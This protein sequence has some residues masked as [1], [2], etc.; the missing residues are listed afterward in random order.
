MRRIV[1]KQIHRNPN[2]EPQIP[3]EEVR[4]NIGEKKS[5]EEM[6]NE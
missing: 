4:G 5:S 6:T 1:T 2:E 3:N